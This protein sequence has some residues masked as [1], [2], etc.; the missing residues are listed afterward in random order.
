VIKISFSQFKSIL[1][2][3]CLFLFNLLLIPATSANTTYDVNQQIMGTVVELPDNSPVSFATVALLSKKDSTILDGVTADEKGAF[4]L[5][6]VKAG[7]YIIRISN[8]GYET[9]FLSDIRISNQNKDLGIIV[10]KAS[11]QRLDE[12]VITAEKSM[13]IEDLD[14]KMIHI[15]K[16]LLATS[17]NVSDLL[18][19]LPAVSLD[20]NGSPQVRG[21][22][23]VVV[24][25]DGKPSTLYGNDL[26]TVLQSFPAEL[27]DRID[28]IT[29]P[30]AKYEGDGASGVIDIITKKVKIKG[31]NGGLRVSLGNKE[32]YNGSGNISYKLGKWGLNASVSAQA[33]NMYWRR[34]LVRDNFLS[35][36]TSTLLQTGTGQ[37]KNNNLFGRMGAS[38]EFNDKNSLSVGVN[39]SLD[40]NKNISGVAN[41]TYVETITTEQFYRSTL[42]KGD[43]NNVSLNLDYRKKFTKKDELFSFTANYSFGNSDGQSNFDQESDSTKLVLHQLNLRNSNNYSVFLNTDYTLPF[44][45]HSK[46]DVGFRTRINKRE[47]VNEFYNY[48]PETNTY[49]FNTE[50]SNIFNYKN[51]IYTGYATYSLKT[52]VWGIRA[53]LR[54]TDS[55][56]YIDQVHTNTA[57]SAHFLTLVPSFAISKKLEEG[58]LLKLNYSRRVQRPE[59][60][61]LN[62]YLDIADPRNTQSG[63]PNLRPEFVHKAELGYSSYK[64]NGGWGPS[65]FMDYSNNAITR[66][67]TVDEL[68]V[69]FTTYDNVGREFTYGFETDFSKKFGEAFKINASG[70]IFRSEVVSEL[71]QIDNRNWSYS[72]NLNAFFNLPMDFKASAYINYQGPRA[73]A[74]GK[75]E[76]VLVANMGIRKDLLKKKATLSANIQD[77]FLSRNYK[78]QLRTSTYLQNSNWQQTNR[79]ITVTMQYRFGKISANE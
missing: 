50:V 39:Y 75:R 33:R 59:A 36:N 45:E 77:I 1:P 17:N 44:N 3:I 9:L 14:K 13:I 4:T 76:G 43:G 27:I 24:L 66:I 60:S 12:V 73:I 62:P 37:N 41:S 2:V 22:G 20:E 18:E 63:N 57:F 58:T 23:N 46:L 51:T 79:L 7:N 72:G 78:N 16:D 65:L 42:G 26:P 29:T 69:S 61:W 67:R 40:N 28:V 48:D 56:Q 6:P 47:N 25:I 52:D 10:M 54:I 19:K 34:K 21:K 8:M 38:Y 53:G 35:E 30:S 32:N 55:D 49:T 74:Q 70:R 11:S 15:G 64:D 31:M 68:G 5:G 71:A